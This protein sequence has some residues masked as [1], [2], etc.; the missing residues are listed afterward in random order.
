VSGM[1]LDFEGIEKLILEN[2]KLVES[3]N[4]NDIKP[5]VLSASVSL[6]TNEGKIDMNDQGKLVLVSPRDGQKIQ[7]AKSKDRICEIKILK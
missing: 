2:I 7:R 4:D 1:D 6:V 3:I 5:I